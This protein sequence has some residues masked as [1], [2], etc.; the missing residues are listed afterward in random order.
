MNERRRKRIRGRRALRPLVLCGAML[1]PALLAGGLLT[2]ELGGYEK[3]MREAAAMV[4]PR[5]G[6]VMPAV[7]PPVRDTAF[8]P[9]LVPPPSLGRAY[10]IVASRR[11]MDVRRSTADAV[12]ADAPGIVRKAL[13]RLSRTRPSGTRAQTPG[14]SETRARMPRLFGMRAQAPKLSEIS[15]VRQMSPKHLRALGFRCPQEWRETWL[16]KVC[17]ERG[18]KES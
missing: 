16:W 7:L 12:P 15:R 11:G 10:E 18:R 9:R 4:G 13:P 2:A 3:G 1:A 14:P 8:E 5:G 17:R 6:V